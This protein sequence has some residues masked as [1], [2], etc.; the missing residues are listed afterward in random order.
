MVAVI[1]DPIK[2][3]YLLKELVLKDIRLRY[4]RPALGFVWAFL[5]PVAMA[6]I[7]YLVFGIFLRVRIQEAPFFL[8]LMSALFPWRMFQ[9]SLSAGATSLYDNRALVRE[10]RAPFY[11]FPLAI[12]LVNMALALPGYALVAVLSAIKLR[13]F[14]AHL[15]ML[16][17]ILVL[18]GVLTAACS[19][20]AAVLFVRWRDI[21]YVIEISLA[22]LFYITP[23]FYSISMVKDLLPA[24]AYR[25]YIYNPFACILALY[26][27]SFIKGFAAH[28]PSVAACFIVVTMAAGVLSALAVLLYKANKRYVIE[29]VSY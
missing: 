27:V 8:Y 6:G 7:F 25:L 21:R 24:Y 28:E 5:M 19:M 18:H 23:G 9:D 26:R 10:S 29:H 17:A 14:P 2:N 22:F 16:P 3:R 1:S 13:G 11:I 15:P 12:V 4:R 20:I